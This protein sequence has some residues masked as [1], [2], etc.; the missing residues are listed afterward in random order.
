MAGAEEI[1]PIVGKTGDFV[2]RQSDLDRLVANQSPETQRLLQSERAK[3][4]FVRQILLTRAL[5]DRARKD[6]FDRK[7]EVKEELSYAI[8]RLLGSIYLRKAVAAGVTVHDDA[9]KAYYTEHETEFVV[10]VKVKARHIFVEAGSDAPAEAQEKARAKAEMVRGL[11][12]KGGDFARL[13]A[14]YSED[15]DSAANGG[16]LGYIEPGK[17]NSE[18]FEK[19]LF[20]LK[21]GKTGPV[22]ETPF[23]YHIVRV[24]ERQDQRTATFDEMKEYIRELL[25]RQ[26]EQEKMQ[27]FLEKLAKDAGLREDS[28]EP[29]LAAGGTAPANREHH[30]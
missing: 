27:S 28:H 4:E 18:A 22:V 16:E 30:E 1:N 25:T 6:G 17:T 12:E 5:A 3:S 26:Y 24:E 13:A 23:G 2:M 8:D 14:E 10:P 9:L 15:E 21:P 19:A 11:L 20:A 7:P 29:D